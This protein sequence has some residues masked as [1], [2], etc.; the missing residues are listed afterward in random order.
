MIPFP[1]SS[2][3]K[4]SITCFAITLLAGLLSMGLLGQGLYYLISPILDL[5]FP[6]MKSWHG[7]WIWPVVLYVS[8]LWPFGFLIGGWT[9]LSLI[10]FGWP[11]ITLYGI[12]I[13]ILLIW[14]SFL[15]F[16]MLNWQPE[17]NLLSSN[18]QFEQ[19]RRL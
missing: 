3:M 7:D 18:F 15:W 4:F 10:K 17:N 9:Y 11:K 6:P 12:Y 5:K 1:S 13:C 14:D 16:I 19:I 2:I 8:I